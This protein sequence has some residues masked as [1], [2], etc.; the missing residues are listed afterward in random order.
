[1]TG[2]LQISINNDTIEL[3]GLVHPDYLAGGARFADAMDEFFQL[4][5]AFLGV[6][7]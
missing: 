6:I 7:R 5:E 3:K 4:Q 1:M 2:Q